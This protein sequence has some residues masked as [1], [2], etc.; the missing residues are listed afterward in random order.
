M[1]LDGTHLSPGV[2]TQPRRF[3]GA[4]RAGALAVIFETAPQDFA[5]TLKIR[6]EKS[7]PKKPPRKCRRKKRIAVAHLSERM[8]WVLSS[9]ASV[10]ATISMCMCKKWFMAESRV[11]MS[12]EITS[13]RSLSDQITSNARTV[14]PRKSIDDTDND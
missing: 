10:S 14:S 11:I 13:R 4:L 5:T 6:P 8:I 12:L 3:H 9:E 1:D 7:A 2:G